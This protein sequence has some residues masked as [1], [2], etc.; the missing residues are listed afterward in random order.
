MKCS[1]NFAKELARRVTDEV[2][3]DHATSLGPTSSHALAE[4]ERRDPLLH[5]RARNHRTLL[6]DARYGMYARLS[7]VPSATRFTDIATS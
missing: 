7:A 4:L 2:L 5:L 6:I 3:Y 1:C